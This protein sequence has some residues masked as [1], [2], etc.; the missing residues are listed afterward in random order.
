MSHPEFSKA[1]QYITADFARGTLFDMVNIFSPKGRESGMAH[2]LHDCMKRASK[3]DIE[4]L[5]VHVR[6]RG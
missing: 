6:F 4:R 1:S 5:A 2:Y 3:A